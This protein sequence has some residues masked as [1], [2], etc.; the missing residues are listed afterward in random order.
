MSHSLVTVYC[1]TIPVFPFRPVTR[2]F[3][4]SF[5]PI[6][7]YSSPTR[8]LF[9]SLGCSGANS[10][11]CHREV[12]AMKVPA[13]TPGSSIP[14]LNLWAIKR[15]RHAKWRKTVTGHSGIHFSRCDDIINA[16]PVWK[17]ATA[18][19]PVL[20]FQLMVVVNGFSIKNRP[21]SICGKTMSLLFLFIMHKIQ[22]LLFQK[23][24][25]WSTDTECF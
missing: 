9:I 23:T 19:L 1:R 11:L 10:L 24:G 2:A 25:V 3:F 15:C 21:T 18:I 16:I 4:R 8:S 17:S 5:H 22:W 7:R 6:L 12:Y 14:C 20:Q 13:K